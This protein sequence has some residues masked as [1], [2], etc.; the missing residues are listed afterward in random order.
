M[1]THKP[2]YQINSWP[3]TEWQHTIKGNV[4]YC[5]W[6]YQ[7]TAYKGIKLT[8]SENNHHPVNLNGT[9]KGHKV[10][11]KLQDQLHVCQSYELHH[12]F[13][14]KNCTQQD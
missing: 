5:T 10:V 9:A 3:H 11:L 13:N 12:C 14:Q 1:Q 7:C 6:Y 2:S 4:L 8:R